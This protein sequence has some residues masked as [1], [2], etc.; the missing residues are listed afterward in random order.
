MAGIVQLEDDGLVNKK[1]KREHP[2]RMFPNLCIKNYNV[3]NT[4]VWNDA[5]NLRRQ[6]L[7]F[8]LNAVRDSTL[9]NG[10]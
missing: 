6:S 8:Y 7:I 5:K 10:R 4:F 9:L 3:F 1:M 2:F